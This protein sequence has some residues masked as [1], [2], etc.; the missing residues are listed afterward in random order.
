MVQYW[1]QSCHRL[2]A[3]GAP[4]SLSPKLQSLR[5]LCQRKR[6]QEWHICKLPTK[7]R[8]SL[9]D[10]SPMLSMAVALNAPCGGE[11]WSTKY[12]HQM[13]FFHHKP[14]LQ[15]SVCSPGPLWQR[16]LH[17]HGLQMLSLMAAVVKILHVEVSR[18][19][20]GKGRLFS[21]NREYEW[22]F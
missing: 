10:I 12:S 2:K 19:K 1:A 8:R 3:V 4:L 11:H 14:L 5:C 17:P 22:L 7:M 18:L 15:T 20:K 21:V 13:V 9:R 6:K 16:L